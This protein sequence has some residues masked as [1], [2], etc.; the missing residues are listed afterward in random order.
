MRCY[1]DDPCEA[2]RVPGSTL[3][4][5]HCQRML[6]QSNMTQ[7]STKVRKQEPVMKGGGLIKVPFC[8]P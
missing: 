7:L 8:G 5:F 2:L 1:I 6:T 3:C 4:L